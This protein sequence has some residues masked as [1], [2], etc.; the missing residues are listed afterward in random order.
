VWSIGRFFLL[1]E[2]ASNALGHRDIDETYRTYGHLLPN[3][4]D[5]AI[6]ALDAEFGRWKFDKNQ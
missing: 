6:A 4:N 1:H 5:K 3:A 2:H